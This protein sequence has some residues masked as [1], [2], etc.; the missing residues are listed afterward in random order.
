M[1]IRDFF[2]TLNYAISILN[3]ESSEE[4][5]SFEDNFDTIMKKAINY[6]KKVLEEEK[7]KQEEGMETN[8]ECDND[9]IVLED[10]YRVVDNTLQNS[11]VSS[12]SKKYIASK[13]LSNHRDIIPELEKEIA[14]RGLEP[15]ED[16]CYTDDFHE[17]LL[18]ALLAI[19][20]DYDFNYKDLDDV[21]PEISEI[22]GNIE[23]DEDKE[24]AF[25]T[26]YEKYGNQKSISFSLRRSL[27]VLSYYKIFG[28]QGYNAKKSNLGIEKIKKTYFIKDYITSY[29]ERFEPIYRRELEGSIVSL[30]SQLERFGEISEKVEIHNNKMKRYNLPGL[31]YY[32]EEKPIYD[33][34]PKVQ[35]LLKEDNLSKLSI[36][37]LLRMNSFYNNRFAK[38]INEYSMALFVIGNLYSVDQCLD[39]EPITKERLGQSKLNAL[40]TKYQTLILPIKASYTE[41]QNE[42]TENAYE[43][44]D[45]SDSIVSEENGSV[46]KR[47]ASVNMDSFVKKVSRVWRN[48]FRE[49]FDSRLPEADNKLEADLYFTDTLYNPVFL[50]YSLKHVALKTEYAYLHY[51][52]QEQPNKSLNFGIVFTRDNFDNRSN[53]ILLASDGELNLPNRLH[54]FKREFTDFLISYTGK[55]LV[56]IYEGFND[57]YFGGEYIASQLLLP[58][59]KQ[60]AS[61]IKA[62]KR[63]KLAE[64]GDRVSNLNPINSRFVEHMEYNFD[65]SKF[66]PSHKVEV[67]RVDKNGRVITEKKQ[68]I[69]YL[70][71]TDG[72]QYIL[73]EDGKLVDK[74]GRV[75]GESAKEERG[76]DE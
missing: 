47:K 50:S 42:V 21:G 69:R 56:R 4:I 76:I 74:N 44:L 30:F 27:M 29:I 45:S 11:D 39:R 58:K 54:T 52:S 5:T 43:Y 71:L 8:I 49:Y 53:S 22:F 64:K 16:E 55:P 35:D 66:M 37:T 31:G 59:A 24:K 3:S 18:T 25:K 9:G 40:M 7:T 51:L 62:L 65:S 57:F 2:S 75:Y 60:H 14:E 15:S 46:I 48:D 41:L 32:S 70:D 73:K 20:K 28:I 12:I 63:G 19:K 38:V 1:R 72:T 13:Y 33:G 36:D 67:T 26:L 10:F 6:I 23:S 17:N 68:P 61:Y 34:L